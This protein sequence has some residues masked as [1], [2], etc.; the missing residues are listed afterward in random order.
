MHALDSFAYVIWRL[1]PH[2][3]VN[4]PNHQHAVFRLHFADHV[5]A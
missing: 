2:G 5:G 3:D 1:E 4:P